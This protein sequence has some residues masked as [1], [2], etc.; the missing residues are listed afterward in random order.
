[1]ACNWQPLGGVKLAAWPTDA[2]R[3]S[4]RDRVIR[5][6]TGPLFRSHAGFAGQEEADHPIK[7]FL[8]F[9]LPGYAIALAVMGLVFWLVRS[10]CTV[11]G[12]LTL[13][14]T[15][16]LGDASYGI[17]LLHGL[18][19]ALAVLIGFALFLI[20]LSKLFMW[21]LLIQVLLTIV[22]AFDSWLALA[23]LV[24]FPFALQAVRTVNRGATGPQ[25]IPV[26]GLTGRAMLIWAVI[27]A[28]AV[29]LV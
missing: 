16:R 5:T 17:Y 13:R 3:A 20:M 7:A 11:F 28:I 27:E 24:Y 19:L 22:I 12:L 18:V 26:L 15:R 23:A 2:V 10:G 9:T 1:M 4:P 25:L 14:A 29:A 21:L 6:I 8:H